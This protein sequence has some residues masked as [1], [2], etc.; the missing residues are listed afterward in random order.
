MKY[1]VVIDNERKGPMTID[2][3][4]QIP[5]LTEQSYIWC[6]GM[7]DWKHAGEVE[8]LKSF[9]NGE[10]VENDEP[11]SES[12]AN[13]T[14]IHESEADVVDEAVETAKNASENGDSAQSTQNGNKAWYEY[15][16]IPNMANCPPTFL[17]LSIFMLLCCCQ[18]FGIV[19]IVY[20]SQVRSLYLSRQY[21]KAERYSRNALI[22]C[23]ISLFAGLF[24]IPLSILWGIFSAL[25]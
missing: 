9:F 20:S 15:G 11:K 6:E 21:E 12:E 13:A 18:V 19:A 16:D 8:E 3:L 25:I 4:K 1:W 10:M 14:E 17:V 5:E 2:E 7:A 24:Y 23:V 22:W